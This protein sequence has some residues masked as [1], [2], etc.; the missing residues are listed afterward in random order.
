MGRGV[1]TVQ[2]VPYENIFSWI[3][4]P[5]QKSYHEVFHFSRIHF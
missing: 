5:T 4:L 3:L 2:C 1:D